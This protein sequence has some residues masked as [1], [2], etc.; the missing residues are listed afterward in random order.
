MARRGYSLGARLFAAA[1][2]PQSADLHRHVT[3]RGSVDHEGRLPL[4]RMRPRDRQTAP[5]RGKLIRSR[6]GRPLYALIFQGVVA[7][8]A[9]RGMNRPIRSLR[10]KGDFDS[11]RRAVAWGLALALI[12]ALT[13]CGFMRWPLTAAKVGDSL[14]AAFGASPRLHWSA[15]RDRLL[16]RLA[17]AER[18]HCRRTARRRLRRQPSVGAG[19]APEPVADRPPARTVH[20]HR[21]CPRQSDGHH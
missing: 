6:L 14:N 16:F 1:F 13:A 19:G 9:V 7:L 12:V 11:M 18:A 21:R 5:P 20:P 8:L 10:P 17:A 2:R 3:Q 15:P 4:G